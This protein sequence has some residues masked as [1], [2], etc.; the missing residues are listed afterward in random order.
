MGTVHIKDSVSV[1]AVASQMLNISYAQIHVGEYESMLLVPCSPSDHLVQEQFE[2]KD[3]RV[4]H[5]KCYCCHYWNIPFRRSPFHEHSQEAQMTVIP[6]SIQRRPS[7]YL[8]PQLWV[9]SSHSCYFRDSDSTKTNLSVFFSA[10]KG[11]M[12]LGSHKGVPSSASQ[13]Q[14]CKYTPFDDCDS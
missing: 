13:D 1:S 8:I 14:C 3:K 6:L 7:S 9:S 2:G 4:P 12:S 5:E 11:S 10:W